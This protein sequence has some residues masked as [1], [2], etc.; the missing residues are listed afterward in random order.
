MHV[1]VINDDCVESGGAAAIALSSIRLLVSHGIKVSLL[2]GDSSD[3][4]ELR[5]LNVNVVR[6]GGS[7]ILDGHRLLA[8]GRGLHDRTTRSRLAE[9]IASNDTG[10]TVYH[11]HNWHKFLSP[12]IFSPLRR[13][14][15]RLVLTAHDYFLV[16]P[17]GGY[18]NYK[19]QKQCELRPASVTCMLTSCD[20]RHY[21]HK[22]WRTTRHAIRSRAF[23]FHDAG[24]TVLALHEGM[25]PFLTRGGLPPDC[26]R[27]LRNPVTPWRQKR[28]E[29]EKNRDIFFVGRLESDKGAQ[30][31]VKAMRDPGWR[32][33]I[34]GDGPL[35]GNLSKQYSNVDFLGRCSKRQIA[36]LVQTAR[37]VV[38]PTLWPETFGLVTMEALT[39]G[40]PVIVSD[41]TFLSR[42]IAE[43]RIGLTFPSGDIP[44]LSS[45]L[46]RIMQDNESVAEMSHLAFQHASSLA[47][48][49]ESWGHALM[50]I[51]QE[52]IAYAKHA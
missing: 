52:K 24:A 15:H 19:V 51:Y 50:Q 7:H 3:N 40:I 2:T 12:S 33:R 8:A 14:G 47:N 46:R 1:V 23:D 36:E 43:R 21:I 34:I 28:V 41:S 18:F 4:P 27:I 5:T 35:R 32:L 11:L 45:Q 13:V 37:C 26:I 31:L 22:I 6:L 42:E 29:V 16:C 48:T 44:A 9:W 25:V 38:V 10:E 20:K 39:S 49:P 17:N 30:L